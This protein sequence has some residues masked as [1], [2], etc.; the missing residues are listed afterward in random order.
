VRFERGCEYLSVVYQAEI[1]VGNRIPGTRKMRL[2]FV[3]GL[4]KRLNDALHGLKRLGGKIR[5]HHEAVYRKWYCR[6]AHVGSIPRRMR[7]G[8]P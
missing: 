6:F 5:R 7:K 3:I 8:C 1:P 2:E 4:C